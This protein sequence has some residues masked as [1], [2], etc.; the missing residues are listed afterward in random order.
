MSLPGLVAF[1]LRRRVTVTMLFVATVVLG[2][3]SYRQL[4]VELMP[5]GFT[6]PEATIWIPAA[7]STPLEVQEQ[8]VRPT[9]EL[10]RT[11]PGV[12]EVA[13]RARQDGARLSV[14][15]GRDIDPTLGLAELRDRVERARA[16]WPAEA[17][18]FFIWQFDIESDLPV[19]AFAVDL[20]RRDDDRLTFLVEEKVLRQIEALPGVARVECWGLLDDQVRIRIDRER[21]NALGVG[22]YQLTQLLEKSNLELSG[23]TVEEGEV[24]V[25]LRTD[26][27]F[28]SLDEV[29]QMPLDRRGLTLGDVAE[30]EAGK[31]VR[32]FMAFSRTKPALWC[33]VFKES[34][35]NTVEVA[36]RV[37][38]FVRDELATDERLLDIGATPRLYEP[39]D[40]GAIVTNALNSLSQTALIGALL[41]LFVLLAFLRRLG[42]TLV[43]TL[44]IPACLMITLAWIWASDGSLNL[45]SMLGITV[46]IGMLIDN[47]IVVVE[48]VTRHRDLG[49][50]PLEAARRGASEV[51]LAI[52]LSTL[53]TVA[54]FLPI[55][56]LTGEGL[57][58]FFAAGIGLPLCVAVG[59]SL[60]V[61]LVFIPLATVVVS[62]RAASGDAPIR[63]SSEGVL[64]RLAVRA[65]GQL[66]RQR[67]WTLVILVTVVGG[68]T[69]VAWEA[70]PKVESRDDSGGRVT[71]DVD[72]DGNL[73]FGDAGR[74]ML[75]IGRWIEEV[76]DEIDLEHFWC[77]F[78]RGSG[79][80]MIDLQHKDML[81]TR[82]TAKWLKE[83]LPERAGV[84]LDISVEGAQSNERG[85]LRLDLFGPDP[86]TLVDLSEQVL[87]V[88]EGVPGVLS[89]SADVEKAEAEI[90]VVPDRESVARKQI[91]PRALRGTITYGIRG[92]RVTDLR[93]D[94]R[95]IPMIIEYEGAADRDLPELQSL[96]IPSNDGREF[97]LDAIADITTSRGLGEIRRRDEQASIR[98]TVES[99]EE[100]REALSEDIR[101]ALAAVPMPD[102]YG[103]QATS[104]A[105]LDSA[106]KTAMSAVLLAAV[107][108]FLLMGVLFESV[109]QPLAVIFSVMFS[110]AGAVWSLA[111]FNTPLDPIGFIA[112]IVLVGVVVNNG[113][114]LIDCAH[115][116]RADGLA[117]TE[118]LL[119]AV[120]IRLRPILMTAVTTIVGLLP[121]AIS[122]GGGS[123]I[124]YRA[125]AHGLIGGL[126]LATFLTLLVVPVIYS[127]LDDLGLFLR[128]V[129]GASLPSPAAEPAR[130]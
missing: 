97:P 91:D 73:T 50:P 26:A 74:E 37:R 49:V 113:I 121:M 38:A 70:V 42:P 80:V 29:R 2:A 27:R 17:R 117:R 89:V 111:L 58:T 120:R 39:A 87:E 90:H 110:W 40:I 96:A 24:R 112:P 44:S 22:I 115:R 4:P 75:F 10:V 105:T 16:S 114:V 82:D 95:E 64:P 8:I 11:I 48:N 98:L 100:D 43:I 129:F 66:L 3:A 88:I 126:V 72:F 116:L 5:G 20:D 124:S 55:I 92:W 47:A 52:T 118:A 30:V 83:R 21:A 15:L 60:F 1:T 125:L 84:K 71:V 78:R 12:K 81:R 14:T 19:F 77:F 59:A 13:T 108:V 104:Q 69:R 63:D 35:A 93:F 119:E 102:G 51:A 62:P 99:A 28:K 7:S 6:E 128:R 34:S 122:D 106:S 18:D 32:Q 9:E 36:D 41:A 127:L 53:T 85:K 45:L 103:F 76:A 54:A 101:T 23:G 123:S 61:A 107:L 46:A 68:I 25:A 94:E 31:G 56:F 109:M 86:G 33:Q 67:F 130:S 79:E 57:V 65:C